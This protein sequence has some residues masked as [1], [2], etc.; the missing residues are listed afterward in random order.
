MAIS[1]AESLRRTLL[2]LIFTSLFLAASCNSKTNDA[3]AGTPAIQQ[4]VLS[5][6]LSY[7]FE[8]DVQLPEIP[9]NQP[10]NLD[11]AQQ[12]ITAQFSNERAEDTVDQIILSPDGRFAAVIYHRDKDADNDFRLDLYTAEG[13][14]LYH[15][16]NDELALRFPQSL[17][18]SP[19]SNKIAFSAAQRHLADAS[20][21]KMPAKSDEPAPN[22]ADKT[23]I[24][25]PVGIPAFRCEQIYLAEA[26]S[27]SVKPLTQHEGFIY[28]EFVFSPDSSKLAAM[29][30]HLSEWRAGERIADQ[31][32][33][34]FQP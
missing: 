15:L 21:T 12:A 14:P 6:Q 32:G 1:R 13:S 19:D 5:T 26:D 31:A 29:A 10:Q 9:H 7:K 16:T 28:Y 27:G 2:T 18:W 25:A 11:A 8:P 34:A 24:R 33:E 4:A 23:A 17:R 20:K 3:G 30:L 22:E